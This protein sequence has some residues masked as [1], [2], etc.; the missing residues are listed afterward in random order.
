MGPRGLKQAPVC[1]RSALP[2]QS[3]TDYS[4]SASGPGSHSRP[5]SPASLWLLRSALPGPPRWESQMPESM[6]PVKK[7]A[8]T[9]RLPLALNPLKSKDVL[10]VL[11]ERNQAIVPVGA[12][13]E[14]ASP[15]SSEIPAYTSAYMIE[16][17]LKEQLRRKQ[18]AL[19]HFQRQVKHRVNQQIRLRKKQQLQKSFKAVSSKQKKKAL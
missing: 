7:S 12:W 5:P 11:A 6:A 2:P 8:N 14:P 18:E 1:P 4:D 17:E 16:E 9:T 13:V 19:K 10:A 15:H 3:D